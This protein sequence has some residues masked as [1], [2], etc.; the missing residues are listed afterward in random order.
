MDTITS[1]C[2]L[3]PSTDALERYRVVRNDWRGGFLREAAAPALATQAV[4][5]TDVPPLCFSHFRFFAFFAFFPIFAPISSTS[6]NHLLTFSQ[7]PVSFSSL[8]CFLY[9]FWS[10]LKVSVRIPLK[11]RSPLLRME[12]QHDFRPIWETVKCFPFFLDALSPFLL[13]GTFLDASLVFLFSFADSFA[14][15]L[16]SDPDSPL[17][18]DNDAAEVLLVTTRPT[19][20]GSVAKCLYLHSLLS[21]DSPH[22]QT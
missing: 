14:W 10:H 4:E 18:I 16:L 6:R 12:Q 20:A 9:C 8:C 21:F 15:S 5:L 7:Q 1:S 3:F 19:G 17:T 11:V 22:P 13:L 2:T